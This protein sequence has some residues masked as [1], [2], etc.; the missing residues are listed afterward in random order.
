MKF[1]VIYRRLG[2]T[3]SFDLPGESFEEAEDHLRAAFHNGEVEKNIASIPVPEF[4]GRF[5]G[6]SE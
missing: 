2:R 3:Y 4:I 5:L 6:G 1:S